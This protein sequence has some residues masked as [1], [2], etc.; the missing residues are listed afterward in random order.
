MQTCDRNGL[1][2]KIRAAKKMRVAPQ[3]KPLRNHLLRLAISSA[4]HGYCQRAGQEISKARKIAEENP[5]SAATLSPRAALRA[6]GNSS[7]RCV[8]RI[9]YFDHDD[10]GQAKEM[11]R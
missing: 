5:T 8:K 1:A 9:A 4:K 6:A 2:K 3:M 10:R 11:I 7:A